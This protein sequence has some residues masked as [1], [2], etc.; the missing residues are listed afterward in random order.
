[1]IVR[2]A[3]SA[4]AAAVCDAVRRSITELCSLDHQG[5][6]ATLDAWLANKTQE[7]FADW[8][9]SDEHISLVVELHGRI[10]GYGLLHRAGAVAL[11]YVAPEAGFQGVSRALLAEIEIRARALGLR[12]L[13]EQFSNRAPVL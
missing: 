8:I 3:G 4:D 13:N 7:S 1:M 5:D 12:A 10:A 11:L 6:E 9:A 2:T